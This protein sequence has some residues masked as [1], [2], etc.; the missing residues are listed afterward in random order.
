MRTKHGLRNPFT[1]PDWLC[2]IG[3]VAEPPGAQEMGK[4]APA[5]LLRELSKNT[6]VLGIFHLCLKEIIALF[7]NQSVSSLQS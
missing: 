4:V 5:E 1:V 3:Q 7:L 6:F 2:D